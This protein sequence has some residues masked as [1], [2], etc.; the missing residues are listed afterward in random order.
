MEMSLIALAA[1]TLVYV[2]FLLKFLTIK[3]NHGYRNLPS[4]SLG[5]P[6]IGETLSFLHAHK[7]EQGAEWIDER[8]A[9]YGP[10][11]KTSLLGTPVVFI[12]GIAGNKF[13]LGSGEDVFATTRPKRISH[14][15]GENNIFELSGSR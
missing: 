12:M 1:I 5:L 2:L 14:L 9:K 8:V 6:L 4:G 11:F 7:K 13:I 3:K 10:V 15:Q